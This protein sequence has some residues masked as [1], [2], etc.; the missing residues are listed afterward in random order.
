MGLFLIRYGMMWYDTGN[1][2]VPTIMHKVGTR[3]PRGKSIGTTV[4][5][6][7]YIVLYRRK[8][9][10]AKSKQIKDM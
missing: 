2:V 9:Q 3:E 8:K 10:K 7:T 6:S 4:A 5:S 1:S